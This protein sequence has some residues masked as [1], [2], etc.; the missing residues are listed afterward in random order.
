MNRLQKKCVIGTVGIHLL[1]LLILIVG[2]AFFNREPKLDNSQILD[3]IPANLVDAAVNS[4]V[5]SAQPPPPTP[6]TMP[7]PVQPLQSIPLP[8]KIVTPPPTPTPTPTPSLLDRVEKYFKPTPTVTPN[9]TPSERQTKPKPDDGIKVST[10]LVKR[11]TPKNT[12]HPDNSRAI[13]NTVRSLSHS[14]SSATKIDMPGNASASYANY[15]DVVISVYHSAWAPPDGMVGDNVTVMFKVTIARDG[16]VI[17]AHIVTPSGDANVDAA[18]QR[19]LDRVTFIAPFPEG[20]D[21]KQRTYPVE[22]NATRN[23]E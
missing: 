18:V 12:S 20:S 5:Q 21:D 14:L 3:V 6:V 11:T 4:G 17:S 19:M 16:T 23:S 10:Q 7:K 1:L 8:P 9:V 15:G 2:P 13:N 22:F